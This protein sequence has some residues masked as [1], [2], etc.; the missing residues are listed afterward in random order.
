MSGKLAHFAFQIAHALLARD[1]LFTSAEHEIERS[2]PIL[3]R[4]TGLGIL[5]CDNCSAL[6]WRIDGVEL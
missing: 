6:G 4:Q 1:E 2:A 5:P 3:S